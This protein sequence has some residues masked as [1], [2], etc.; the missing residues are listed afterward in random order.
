MK[1]EEVADIVAGVPI[2]TKLELLYGERFISDPV[3]LLGM[4][5]E[6]IILF[7]DPD[8]SIFIYAVFV[9]GYWSDPRNKRIVV[10]TTSDFDEEWFVDRTAHAL[11][12]LRIVEPVSGERVDLRT[13]QIGQ[14]L[15]YVAGQDDRYVGADVEV[16]GTPGF[17]GCMVKILRIHQKDNPVTIAVGD[18]ILAGARELFVLID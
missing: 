1:K 7:D 16:V 3:Y 18:E 2:G 15:R 17:T 4:V 13:L 5:N 12:A 11:E 10:I 8:Q 6:G 9:S 14:K